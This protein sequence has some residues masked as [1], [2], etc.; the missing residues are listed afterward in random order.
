LAF[1]GGWLRL[2]RRSTDPVHGASLRVRGSTKAANRVV[3]QLEEAA[4]A[5]DAVRFINTAR[6]ALQRTTGGDS[7]ADGS[8]IRQLLALA[9]EA[10]YSGHTP[11][12]VDFARWTQIVRR[13]MMGEKI[14]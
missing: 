13:R 11:A 9:D 6:S 1:A 3:A 12:S 8:D 4:R 5:G 10:N 2:R 14:S 7:D